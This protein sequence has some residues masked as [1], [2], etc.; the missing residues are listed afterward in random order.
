MK[1]FRYVCLLFIFSFVGCSEKPADIITCAGA[2]SEGSVWVSI[3]SDNQVTI[4]SS[5]FSES[6]LRSKHQVVKQSC[7]S[8]I[9]IIQADKYAKNKVVYDT[10]Q[11]IKSLGYQV[12]Q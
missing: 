12:S 2:V 6:L 1:K 5:Q 4:G 8:V 7:D 9:V 10:I 11:K 3:S